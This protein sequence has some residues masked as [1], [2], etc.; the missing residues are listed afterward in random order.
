MCPLCCVV[1]VPL[2]RRCVVV[3]S[4]LCCRRRCAVVVVSSL[5]CVVITSHFAI[6]FHARDTRCR[7]G[8]RVQVGQRTDI[9]I[10]Q[11]LSLR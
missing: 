11:M 3:V 8:G 6:F 10:H 4:S 2:C 9:K 1:V 5:C 7:P